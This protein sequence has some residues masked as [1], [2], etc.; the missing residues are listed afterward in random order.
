MDTSR[1][2]MIKF[3]NQPSS[4]SSNEGGND[5]F[6]KLYCTRQCY[7]IT[8]CM[9]ASVLDCAVTFTCD[10]NVCVYGIQ[11]PSQVV[12]ENTVD[13][14]QQQSFT[15]NTYPELLYAH[16]LD[17]DGSRLTY[18]HFTSRVPYK[19]LIDLSFNR[20]VFIQRNKVMMIF[21]FFGLMN[22]SSYFVL[23]IQSWSGIKQ[24]GLVPDR[25]LYKSDRL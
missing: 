1:T 21:L 17:A 11:I 4:S 10:K 6:K 12:M 16:L 25:F 2:S 24:D 5:S 20:P 14:R 9:N 7:C 18:T 19:S 8:E 23:G 15:N 13:D 3:Y 22:R